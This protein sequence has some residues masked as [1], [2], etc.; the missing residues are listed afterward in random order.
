MTYFHTVK[1]GVPQKGMISWQTK[2]SPSDMRDVSSYI[3]TLK[4]TNPPNPKQPEGELYVPKE[5]P[6]EGGDGLPEAQPADSL[7][8]AMK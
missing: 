2:L 3:L 8:V 4:G 7:E 5:V 1:Y 6:P